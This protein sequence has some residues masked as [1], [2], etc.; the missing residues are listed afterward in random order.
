LLAPE[1]GEGEL[2]YGD[3]CYLVA[4]CSMVNERYY[5]FVQGS[6]EAIPKLKYLAWRDLSFLVSGSQPQR[7]YHKLAKP[8]VQTLWREP[9]PEKARF[10]LDNLP[11]MPS[12][13]QIPIAGYGS[14][15]QAEAGLVG[16]M[17]LAGRPWDNILATFQKHQ[18]AHYANHNNPPWYLR[19]T[20]EKC[21]GAIASDP[22]RLGIARAYRNAAL[23]PWPG[24]GGELE[25]YTLLALLTIAWEFDAWRVRASQRDLATLAC[26]T[27][28]GVGKALDRL[29]NDGHIRKT[30][31]WQWVKDMAKA[32]TYKV[33]GENSENTFSDSHSSVVSSGAFSA[34]LSS[35]SSPQRSPTG[36]TPIGLHPIWSTQALG[37]SAGHIYDLIATG[38]KTQSELIEGSGKARPT[39]KKALGILQSRQLIRQDGDGWALGETT[40]DDVAR[41]EG[42]EGL[43]ARRRRR[44]EAQRRAFYTEKPLYIQRRN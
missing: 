2:R 6:P 8:P 28:R 41:A 22:T 42:H 19:L 16:M 33:N 39:V 31:G 15:S 29:E 13:K 7:H 27:Q 1:V 10:L 32:A 36:T 4:P 9:L 11:F 40:K 34:S 24:T 18:P 26:A 3:G 5:S 21:L 44:Y 14:V 38:A 12:G 23:A 17:I 30:F 37:R 25:R 20:Y 43:R 35:P